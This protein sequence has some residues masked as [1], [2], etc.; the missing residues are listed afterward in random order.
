MGWKIDKKEYLLSGQPSM[1][2]SHWLL[3]TLGPV[4]LLMFRYTVMSL[5]RERWMWEERREG[6][7]E[8]LVE[9]Q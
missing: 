9:S 5:L 6:D 3:W 7:E 1:S 4:R 8:M 2:G